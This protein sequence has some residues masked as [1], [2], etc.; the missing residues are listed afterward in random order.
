M[1]AQFS[2]KTFAKD[3]VARDEKG[4]PFGR[5]VLPSDFKYFEGIDKIPVLLLKVPKIISKSVLGHIVYIDGLKYR[6][7]MDIPKFRVNARMDDWV[8]ASFYLERVL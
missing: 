3:F 1:D 7:P 6:I 2:P 5:A 4:R 8:V